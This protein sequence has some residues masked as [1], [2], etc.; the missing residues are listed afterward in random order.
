MYADYILI[1]Q[2]A[3]HILGVDLNDNEC[4]KHHPLH[5]GQLPPH[6]GHQ[7]TELKESGN[8]WR[9]LGS[10]DPQPLHRG[11]ASATESVYI[12]E[13]STDPRWEERKDQD[14]GRQKNIQVTYVGLE[15]VVYNSSVCSWLEMGSA[16]Q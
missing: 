9:N 5:A 11:R 8:H 6:Q 7:V 16:G 12:Q 13:A 4:R 2:L 1:D 10:I 15:S 3:H 14:R